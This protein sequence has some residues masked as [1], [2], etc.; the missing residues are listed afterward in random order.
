MPLFAPAI[1]FVDLE[2]TGTR[3]RIDRITEVGIVRVAADPAGGPPCVDEWSSLVDPGKPI[4]PAIQALTG[5]TDTMVRSAPTF[6]SVVRDVEERLKGC[7]FVA[8]NA[9]FDYGFL[10]NEFARLE[11][12]FKAKVLCTVRL[13]RRL[14]PEAPSHSLDAVI[15]RH[16]LSIAARHRALDDAQA[17]WQFVQALYATLPADGIEAAVRRVLKI[18]SLPPQLAPDVLDGVPECAGVYLFYGDNPLP[19]YIGKSKNL[20]E[21]VSAHFSSDWASETDLR[22]SA[23]IR[24]IECEPT[25]GELGAL[26]R[27]ARLVKSLLPAH[28]RALR[29]KADAGVMTLREDGTPAFVAAAAYVPGVTMPAY[30][31]FSSRHAMREALAALARDHALCWKRLGLERRPGPCFSRQLKRCPGACDGGE[32][33]GAHDAR[34]RAAVARLAIPAWPFDGPALVREASADGER[35]DVHVVRDWAWLGTARDDSELYALLE[36]PRQ[37]EFDVDVTKLLLRTWSKRRSAF[38]AASAVARTERASM[39]LDV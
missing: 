13:S 10:K 2:T 38:V 15:E 12:P 22:L 37:P 32:P 26:L 20:R 39:A 19:L 14:F 11:R 7:V 28:N 3:A 31:P 34:F 17:L 4:P 8:H 18:P 25:A 5:I 21:R 24:R 9:R 1:A 27:E 23:E 36:S 16:G 6:G 29:R 33:I 30:G 35:V